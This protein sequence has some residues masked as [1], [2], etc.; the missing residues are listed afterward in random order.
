MREAVLRRLQYWLVTGN[1]TRQIIATV[2]LCSIVGV[3]GGALFAFLGPLLAV[4]ILGAATVGLVMLRSPQITFFALIGVI[5][6]LPFGALPV[7]NIGFS[8]TFL[9]VILVVLLFSWLFQV[10]RKKQ[11]HILGSSLGLPVLVFAVLA[12]ASFV[13]GLSYA[14]LTTSIL[15]QFAELLLNLVLFFLVINIARTERHV[16]GIVTVLILAAFVASSIGLVL[17]FLP[18][19]LTI[20]LLSTLRVFRYPSGSDVLVYIENDASLPLRAT[21]TSINPNALAGML[22]MVASL[23]VAQ[24]LAQ[25]PL[26]LLRRGP[27]WGGINW[28]AVPLL[29]SMLLCLLLT[30]SRSAMAGFAAAVV[31]IALLRYRKLLLL[32]ALAGLLL[33]FLP[34][35]QWYV[36]RFVG[37]LRGEDRAMQM[38]F[39]EYKDA[40]ILIARYPWFGVGFSGSPDIDVYIGVSSVYLL[41]AEQMGLIGLGVFLLIMI[42]VVREVLRGLSRLADSPAL[43]SLLLGLFA[44]LLSALFTG[45]A[46]HYFVNIKFQH[47]V[48]L[49]WLCVGLNVAVTLLPQAH[50]PQDNP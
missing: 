11:R 25:K 24:L 43:E 45:I 48:A 23:T 21:S 27:H 47:A 41:V 9:D 28:L 46:D 20:R 12:C 16:Q 49:L 18:E 7:P 10:A 40:L 26:P 17:H 22:T 14:E 6:L 33:L 19:D 37:G 30:Y 8:P 50:L 1:R 2:I 4:A 29:G 35:T 32:M 3:A 39:G 44:A 34:Q 38:R 13:M 5:C 15:R 36:Q 31:V 42:L